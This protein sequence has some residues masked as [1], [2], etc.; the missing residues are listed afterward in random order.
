MQR[1]NDI[2][3]LPVRIIIDF[4]KYLKMKGEKN[5]SVPMAKESQD[6]LESDSYSKKEIMKAAN[7][8]NAD[9]EVLFLF[10]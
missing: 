6:A 1:Q 7:I 10:R 5:V 4:G 2:N 9:I 8:N 3:K